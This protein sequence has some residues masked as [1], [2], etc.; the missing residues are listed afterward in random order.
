LFGL[1]KESEYD[2]LT[3]F[4]LVFVVVHLQDLLERLGIDALAKVK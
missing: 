4:A 3:E 2:R 1:L